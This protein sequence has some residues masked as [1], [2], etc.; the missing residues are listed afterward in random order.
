MDVV[1]WPSIAITPTAATVVFVTIISPE[2]LKLP[3]IVKL[4]PLFHSQSIFQ[5]IAQ[6]I[7]L[8]T[9]FLITQIK[10]Q[11]PS[12]EFQMPFGAAQGDPSQPHL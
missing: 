10:I 2:L 4:F 7:F 5:I 1:T 3:P 9:K 11:S 6:G 12:F 8:K